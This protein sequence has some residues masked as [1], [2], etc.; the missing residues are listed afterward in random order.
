MITLKKRYEREFKKYSKVYFVG[1]GA[2][3]IDES[4]S[5][6][7]QAVEEPEYY[8]SLGNLYFKEKQLA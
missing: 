1:G 2:Y 8:N 4:I 5:P 7:I 3:F 6:I